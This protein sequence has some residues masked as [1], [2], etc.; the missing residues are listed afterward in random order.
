MAE[1]SIETGNNQFVGVS[2]DTIVIG[3]PKRVMTK[4]EA[5]LHAAWLVAMAD[6]KGDFPAVLKAVRNT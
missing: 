2:G 4:R 1:E 5:V 6:E 3:N